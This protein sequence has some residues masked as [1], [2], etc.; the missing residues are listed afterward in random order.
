MIVTKN[1]EQRRKALAKSTSNAEDFIVFT[2][3]GRKTCYYQILGSSPTYSSTDDENIAALAKDIGL[4]FED[5]R[6][7]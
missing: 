1:E 3:Y 6:L 7:L 5:L 2:G 4:T